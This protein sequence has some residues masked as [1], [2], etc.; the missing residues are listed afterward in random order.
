MKSVYPL[1]GA[2]E[3]GVQ[4]V[5]MH[6][7]SGKEELPDPLKY[8]VLIDAPPRFSDLPPVLCLAYSSLSCF[9]LARYHKKGPV[10]GRKI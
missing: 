2:V 10:E 3:P 1:A 6:I 5:Q 7:F 4:G 9:D 8:L